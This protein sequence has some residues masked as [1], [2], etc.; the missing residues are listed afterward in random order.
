MARNKRGQVS[1][2]LDLTFEGWETENKTK[3]NP[4]IDPV[5]TGATEK[6]GGKSRLERETDHLKDE[7]SIG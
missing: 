1:L 5:V 6:R 2:L 7:N 4:E 3:H